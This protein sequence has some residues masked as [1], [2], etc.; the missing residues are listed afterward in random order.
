MVL[1]LHLAVSMLFVALVAFS[2]PLIGV[3]D[4]P[5]SDAKAEPIKVA[6]ENKKAKKSKKSKKS[7][8]VLIGGADMRRD[9]SVAGK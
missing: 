6:T 1:R 2:K 9:G 7:K 4:Q 3:E 5:P 8:T